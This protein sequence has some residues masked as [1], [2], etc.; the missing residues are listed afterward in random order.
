MNYSRSA[1]PH[2]IGASQCIRSP[3]MEVSQG[4]DWSALRLI[5]TVLLDKGAQDGEPVL[6]HGPKPPRYGSIV[7]AVLAG[8]LYRK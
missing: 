5:S 6:V 8:D 3:D 4:M 1:A 7:L 2:T